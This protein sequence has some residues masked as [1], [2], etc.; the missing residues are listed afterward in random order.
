MAWHG[1]AW[2]GETRHSLTKRAG[3]WLI[4]RSM[5][6]HVLAQRNWT[7]L[8]TYRLARP[9]SPKLAIAQHSGTQRIKTQL[10]TQGEARLGM[11]RHDR[12]WPKMLGWARRGGAG[13][14][15]ARPG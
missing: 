8:D 13:R 7:L 3:A 15:T 5:A 14:G 11:A 1:S 12:A 4:L 6:L 10:K 9:N 2:R